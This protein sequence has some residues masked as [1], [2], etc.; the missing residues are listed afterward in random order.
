MGVDVISTEKM[1][2]IFTGSAEEI[3]R[4]KY[5]CGFLDLMDIHELRLTF[6]EAEKRLAD[7]NAALHARKTKLGEDIARLREKHGAAPSNLTPEKA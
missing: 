3:R 4:Q 2:Y 7:E 6:K 5:A 1:T